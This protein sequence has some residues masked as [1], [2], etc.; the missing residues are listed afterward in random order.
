MDEVP[1]A[2]DSRSEGPVHILP[3]VMLGHVW[4]P[5]KNGLIGGLLEAEEYR[6]VD[7]PVQAYVLGNRFTQCF[8]QKYVPK[9][10]MLPFFTLRRALRGAS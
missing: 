8:R 10:D 7:Q 5:A 1:G 3:T 6:F 2:G 4:L 9:L